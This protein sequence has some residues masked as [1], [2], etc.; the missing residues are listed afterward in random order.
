[1]NYIVFEAGNKE[2]KLK[3]NTGATV[4]LEKR[5]GCNPISIFGNGDEIPTITTMVSILHAS[6]QAYNHGITLEDAY[7]IFDNWL[8]DGNAMT[9]FFKII[10]DIYKVSGLMRNGDEKNA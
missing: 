3:L 10:I 4:A 7:T 1:M 5:L 6:L 2:Y 8:D 9:D